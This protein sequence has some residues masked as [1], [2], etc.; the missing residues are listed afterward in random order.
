MLIKYTKRKKPPVQ[1]VNVIIVACAVI[2]SIDT[3]NQK[4]IMKQYTR[5]ILSTMTLILNT[6]INFG[7]SKSLRKYSVKRSKTP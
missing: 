4:M 7:G 2:H 3:C 6:A 1:G 5:Y